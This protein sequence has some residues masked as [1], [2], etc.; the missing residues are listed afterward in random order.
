[1]LEVSGSINTPEHMFSSSLMPVF[2]LA[3]FPAIHV[4]FLAVNKPIDQRMN[5]LITMLS[6]ST[7]TN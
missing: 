4:G 5:E 7:T 1:M 2:N 6:V 3:L